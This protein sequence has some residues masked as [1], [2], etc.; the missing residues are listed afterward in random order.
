MDCVN[1][2]QHIFPVTLSFQRINIFFLFE[3]AVEIN[4]SALHYH[5]DMMISNFT[6]NK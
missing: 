4:I 2:F 1:S 6:K 3:P 5:V